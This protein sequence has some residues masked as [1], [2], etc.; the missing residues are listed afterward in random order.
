M[1]GIRVDA[2]QT[3]SGPSPLDQKGRRGSRTALAV[4][5]VGIA[6]AVAPG[7]ARAAA[8]V[9]FFP[10]R[11][12]DATPQN[13]AAT[14]CATEVTW[15][16]TWTPVGLQAESSTDAPTNPS[17]AEFD[18]VISMS[19]YPG[20]YVAKKG[21]YIFFRARV[22]WG[23]AV[24]S[25]NGAPYVAASAEGSNGTGT[26]FWLLT[27]TNPASDVAPKWAISWDNLRPIGTHGLE[28]NYQDSINPTKWTQLNFNDV[29][30]SNS[31]RC[32]YD[33]DGP[34][35]GCATTVNASRREG[36]V[37]TYDQQTYNGA[38][39]SALFVEF[40]VACSYFTRAAAQTGMN[41]FNPCTT[42]F[43]SS[44]AMGYQDD[45]TDWT[46]G[47]A[48][49]DVFGITTWSNATAITSSLSWGS[50][51]DPTAVVVAGV[52]SRATPHG[53]EVHWKTA[54]EVGTAG[55]NLYRKDPATGSP[56][57][58]NESLVPALPGSPNGARYAVL[59]PDA[60][61]GTASIYVLE[62]IEFQGTSRSYGPFT[63]RPEHHDASPEAGN[64]SVFARFS[65][66]PGAGPLLAI[67]PQAAYSPR[68]GAGA[69]PPSPLHPGGPGRRLPR[70]HVAGTGSP[71]RPPCH[72]E[73]GR[74]ARSLVVTTNRIYDEYSGGNL[75]PAGHPELP[76]RRSPDVAR[77]HPRFVVLVGHGKLRRP[78]RPRRG[79][80]PRLPMLVTTPYG[81]A[82][83]DVALADVDGDDGVPEFAI[84]R[85][86]A[87]TEA[88]LTAYLGK[89]DAYELASGP[90]VGRALFLADNGDN[91]GDF[92]VDSAASAARLRWD[93]GRPLRRTCAGDAT[94][95][96]GQV[97]A[98]ARRGGR[99]LPLLR[100]RR[101]RPAGLRG[102]LHVDRHRIRSAN[103]DRTPL[104]MLMT[105]MAGILRLPRVRQP[106][107]CA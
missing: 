20:F 9:C 84:G 45:N 7:A 44:A 68:G 80:Q 86:P 17:L 1:A 3:V 16:T 57:Q 87:S 106:G 88:E 51:F 54:S 79:R 26:L 6:L 28:M 10:E 61:L 82:S 77:V 29:D 91:G 38:A 101:G 27:T 105:C 50:S 24:N 59:D 22:N 46:G 104:A 60:P 99:A 15:P 67:R 64:G 81:L 14:K 66:P 83:S 58:V 40:A 65:P 30:G 72:D 12:N 5:L 31:T 21:D 92:G 23:S 39:N 102:T 94:A 73:A 25:T 18:N 43:W 93:D 98:G 76:R 2:T 69:R 55:F 63:V 97:I 35:S 34:A 70:H 42:P 75:D 8:Y 53:I 78:R 107:R 52:R 100:P 89:L 19:G 41:S 85:I 71:A 95:T 90:W 13:Y 62:E 103:A 48:K 56:V 11:P 32:E 47:N 49:I 4:V 96:R 74:G 37:R 33:F 36:Y